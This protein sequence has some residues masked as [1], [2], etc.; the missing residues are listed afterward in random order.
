MRVGGKSRRITQFVA[1]VF[2][3]LLAD[4]AF[5]KSAGINAG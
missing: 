1:I 4:A 3:L 2:Y 5:Q